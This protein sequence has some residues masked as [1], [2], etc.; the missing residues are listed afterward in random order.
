MTRK[1]KS[2]HR[3][4]TVAGSDSG[5]GAGVQAD[6]KTM[7][8]LGCYGM[9][10]FAALTAQNTKEV[11]AIHEVP[12]TFLA[13]QIDAVVE[14]IGVDAVKIGML[15]N[16]E[17]IQ[18]V[19]DRI[20]EYQ[21][22]K[23]VLDPVMV[24][25]S[26]HQLIEDEAIEVLQ[27][28]LFPLCEVI[29]PNLPEAEK[30][31]DTD[32]KTEDDI[33]T[34]ARDL[35]QMGPRAVLLKGGHLLEESES[36]DCLVMALPGDKG[37]DIHWYRSRRIDTSNTHGTGCTLSSAIASARAKGKSLPE[38][39][40]TAKNYITEAI[41]AGSEYQLGEGSGPLHHFYQTWT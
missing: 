17:L 9:S 6:L 22:E 21:L 31:L 7:S 20:E 26:G 23:V 5:G 27:T 28:T 14:D 13:A 37:I 11:R 39:V 34:A 32:I 41:R 36:A 10:A 38:A 29:T 4:L 40:Q 16:A 25:Q 18:A 15:F 24:S 33:E 30:L 3:V 8:A 1:P 35:L 2:Y 12:P 19:A